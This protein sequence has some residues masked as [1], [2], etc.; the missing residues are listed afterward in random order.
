MHQTTKKICSRLH[1]SL[2]KILEKFYPTIGS[3]KDLNNVERITK[4]L[5]RNIQFHNTSK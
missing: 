1:R 2:E 4:E 5:K 3:K